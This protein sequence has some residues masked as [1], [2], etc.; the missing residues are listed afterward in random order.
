MDQLLTILHNQC[1]PNVQRFNE[2]SLGKVVAHCFQVL[3][4]LRAELLDSL[5]LPNGQLSWPNMLIHQAV[6]GKDGLSCDCQRWS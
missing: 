6:Q 4:C 5:D 2:P 3:D 1:H